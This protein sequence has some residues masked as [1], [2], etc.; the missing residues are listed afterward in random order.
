MTSKQYLVATCAFVPFGPK[1]VELMLKYFS[2]AKGIWNATFNDLTKLGLSEKIV[3]AFV[4]YREDFDISTYFNKL[5]RLKIE[6]LTLDDKEYPSLLKR[7]DSA[8]RVLY[9]K[10]S[11][12]S[13]DVNAVSIVGTRKMSSYGK[14]VTQMFASRLAE[15]GIT[16]VSGL[17]RG[18]DTTA[19]KAALTTGGRTIAVMGCGLDKVYPP[20]N[21][22]LA[23]DII[24]SGAV[25]SEYPL[26]YPALRVNFAARNRIVAA[27][28][29]AVLV[30]EGRGK[31][32]TLLTASAAAEQGIEVFAVPGE[33]TSP[34]SEAPHFLLKNGA[35]I[36]TAPE[37]ILAEL[38][39]NLKVDKGQVEKLMP[40]DKREE[41]LIALLESQKMHLDEISRKINLPVSDI[42]AR[43][44]I[45]EIK[46]LV[47]NMGGGVY[48]KI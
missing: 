42:S 40:S 35:K 27:L 44:A 16:V 19:H 31:S 29:R 5:K 11:F 32:G 13:N 6:I 37:D 33:I 3:E 23:D 45:M 20:E 36:A 24:A 8:P 39:L 38:D 43:L 48:R 30:V 12:G 18:V 41:D 25:I 1:R 15:L 21:A 9:V 4:G 14:E 7:I 22:R 10:G 28:S 2:N 47:K 17:A 46:G 26:G 34:N